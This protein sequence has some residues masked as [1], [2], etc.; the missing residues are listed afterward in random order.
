M[1]VRLQT[2][3]P[4]PQVT[5]PSTPWTSRT[6]KTLLEAQLYSKYL[7]KRITN[8]KSSSPESIIHAVKYFEKGNTILIHEVAILKDRVRQLEQA[9]QVVG[10]SRRRERTRL[11]KGGPLTL[12]ETS[13]SIDQMDVDTQVAAESSRSGGRRS[14]GPRVMH[15][16]TC[17]KAGHNT[18]TCQEEIEVEMEEYSD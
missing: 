8:H 9:N 13:Q 11:Q 1:D 2:L 10:R 17:G 14:Q 15:C 7:Q 18:R 5:A 6:L 3:T 4:P 16:G 12:G